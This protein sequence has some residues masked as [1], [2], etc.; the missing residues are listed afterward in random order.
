M[1]LAAC[2][3]RRGRFAFKRY[4]SVNRAGETIYDMLNYVTV[5]VKVIYINSAI[6]GCS[7]NRNEQSL[8]K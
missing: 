8:L 4:D 7:L 2:L 3:R 6:T 1:R 5:L